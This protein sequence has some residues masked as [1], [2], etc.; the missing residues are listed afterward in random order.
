M[1]QPDLI[2]NLCNV[3]KFVRV[4]TV[5]LLRGWR[6]KRI[7]GLVSARL[8]LS[9][10]GCAEYINF[11]QLNRLLFF[12]FKVSAVLVHF[13]LTRIFASGERAKVFLVV[14]ILLHF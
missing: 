7:F 4:N 8:R 1:Q 3:L 13:V 10:V 9:F 2:V 6:G 11:K 14:T 5:I 12:L